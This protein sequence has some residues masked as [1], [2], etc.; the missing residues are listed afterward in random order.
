MFGLELELIHNIFPKYAGKDH[1]LCVEILLQSY[2][3][4]EALANLP[5]AHTVVDL[6]GV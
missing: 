4:R 1:R 2:K 3:I 6:E 5:L